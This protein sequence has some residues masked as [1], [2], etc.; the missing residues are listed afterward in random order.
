M[1]YLLA[2]AAA[3]TMALAAWHATRPA[4]DALPAA[5][6]GPDG[7]GLSVAVTE[8][9]V[10]SVACPSTVPV[11]FVVTNSSATPLRILGATDAC[12]GAACF[13]PRSPEPVGVPARGTYRYHAELRTRRPGPF[14]CTMD[15]FLESDGIRKVTVTARGSSTTD[16]GVA[17]PEDAG[18]E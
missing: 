9:D 10:G 17:V 8:Q 6:A 11:S 12:F 15:L 16:P 3:V 2:V 5:A 18:D 1:K 14:E 4:P 13:G 7:G